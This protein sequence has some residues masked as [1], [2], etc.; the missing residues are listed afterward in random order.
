[1][2]NQLKSVMRYTS[3]AQIRE[4]DIARMASNTLEAFA[5]KLPLGVQSRLSP[6]INRSKGAALAVS[7]RPMASRSPKLAATA[8]LG[9]TAPTVP[10]AAPARMDRNKRNP[11]LT[12]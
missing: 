5:S 10:A 8:T 9:A 7:E 1:M 11:T 12:M 4:E 6:M 2:A 3:S